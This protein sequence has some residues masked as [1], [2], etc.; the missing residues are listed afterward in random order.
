[1]WIYAKMEMYWRNFSSFISW[2]SIIFGFRTHYRNSFHV[3][4]TLS[5]NSKVL[6]LCK[7]LNSLSFTFIINKHNFVSVLISISSGV[8]GDHT[9]SI[10]VQ[11][12]KSRWILS[13]MSFSYLKLL[14]TFIYNFDE[15]I[16]LNV[17][18]KFHMKF[19][20]K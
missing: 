14:L 19:I 17:E 18:K 3:D 7:V 20:W 15:N 9:A 8:P 10:Q 5:F 2:I 12:L 11:Y 1:M 4:D 13:E 6:A 16:C